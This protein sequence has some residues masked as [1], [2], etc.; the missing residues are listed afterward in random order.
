MRNRLR[1][2]V[3][4][5]SIAAAAMSGSLAFAVP[6]TS[7]SAAEAAPTSAHAISHTT[8]YRGDLAARDAF[9]GCTNRWN[10]GRTT[11]VKNVSCGRTISVRVLYYAL[12]TPDRTAC[13][14]ISP[15]GTGV[16]GWPSAAFRYHSIALC[17]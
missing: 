6:G 11:Y 16:F 10:S 7:L 2:A 13:Q 4:T 8:R 12:G 14:S 9:P 1:S 15:G 17:G 3:I 5:T